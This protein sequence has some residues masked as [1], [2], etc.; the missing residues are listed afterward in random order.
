MP[1]KQIIQKSSKVDPKRKVLVFALAAIL[2]LSALTY[3]A[4]KTPVGE[5]VLSS[6]AKTKKKDGK[7]CEGAKPNCGS[8][9]EAICKGGDWKCVSNEKAANYNGTSGN[10]NPP[11]KTPTP[12]PCVNEKNNGANCSSLP[13]CKNIT[14]DKCA[15]GSLFNSAS[16]CKVTTGPNQV[17]V[18]SCCGTNMK[19]KLNPD[20][21]GYGCYI[22]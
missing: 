12:K 11:P 21:K 3:V 4:A 14:S 13:D 20:G 19:K 5:Y 15:Q 8:K 2:G 18:W 10:N 17:T 1:K 9:K 22:N 6:F 7:K 16:K